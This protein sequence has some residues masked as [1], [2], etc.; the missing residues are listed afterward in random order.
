MTAPTTSAE[1]LAQLVHVDPAAARRVHRCALC[2]DPMP[3]PRTCAGCVSRQAIERLAAAGAA[4]LEQIP[5][6]SRSITRAHPLMTP[7][8]ADAYG[9]AAHALRVGKLAVLLRGEPGAGKT[10]VLAA[11]AHQ[12]AARAADDK[13]MS[14]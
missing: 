7:G 8:R 3:S 14:V 1:V 10:T 11:L 13:A 5:E 9:A 2:L 4:C 12:I 6:R